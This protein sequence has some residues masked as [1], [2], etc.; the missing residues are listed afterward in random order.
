[1][2]SQT[3]DTVVEE[4][5]EGEPAQRLNL[6]VEITNVGPCRKHVNI[7]VPEEDIGRIR[8]DAVGELADKAQVPGFQLFDQQLQFFQ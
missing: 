8:E 7:T 5:S 4:E 6:G 3:E 1:M 2:N